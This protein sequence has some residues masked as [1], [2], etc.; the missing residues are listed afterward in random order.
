MV[1]GVWG[2]MSAHMRRPIYWS[3][4]AGELLFTPVF[5]S[6]VLRFGIWN[7]MSAGTLAILIA[8]ALFRCVCLFL[9]PHWFGDQDIALY[10]VN[11][12]R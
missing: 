8:I 4:L 5:C 11:K 3:L 9:R 2:R 1:F 6:F 7:W 10:P 12:T